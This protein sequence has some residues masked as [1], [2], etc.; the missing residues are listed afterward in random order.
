MELHNIK[1]HLQNHLSDGLVLIVGS[2]LSCAEG[3]PG[4]NA[5]AKH[6]IDEIPKII[7]SDDLN[8]WTDVAEL[9]GK[10]VDLESALLKIT[11]TDTLE[12]AV[13][14]ATH[15]FV[16]LHEAKVVNEISNGKRILKFSKLLRHLLKPNTGIPVITT[17]YDRLIEIAVESVGL[18]VNNLSTGNYFGSFNPKESQLSMCRSLQ[19]RRKR[20]YIK[21]A[22]FVTVLKP[23]GSV[24][25]FLI[26]DE[27]IYSSIISG[28]RKLIITP[29][30]NKFRGGYDRPFD[31]HRELA[32]KSIDN[33]SRYLIIGYG[34]NDDHLQVHLKQQL[35][36]G[37]PAVI[38][39]HSITGTTR[40]YLQK[41]ENIWAIV[42]RD[43][44]DNG[45]KLIVGENEFE[46]D[47]LNIWDLEEFVKEVLE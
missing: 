23:H 9:L 20:T 26:N 44:G 36:H 13:I 3:I 12:T 1:E 38:L 10:G 45:F 37:K 14:D 11:L 47:D 29:G 2:G 6:L 7:K 18:S 43:G 40:E 32:N 42:H 16:L 34:F 41:Y 35:K 46:F 4:M 5:L 22:D 19:Y 27:P 33:A 25:W 8:L 31:S 17:N 21:N 15:A 39:T 30:V 24:D 28:G